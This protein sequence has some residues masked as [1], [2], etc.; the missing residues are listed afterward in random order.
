MQ[1][2]YRQELSSL[3]PKNE[4][5]RFIKHHLINFSKRIIY[6]Y[7]ILD[8][9]IGTLELLGF[10]FSS[11]LLSIV[12]IKVYLDGAVNQAYATPGSANLVSLLA[13]ITVQMLIGFLYFDATQQPLARR[14]SKIHYHIHN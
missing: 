4:I 11:L 12:S 14:R 3:Q 13:I 6:Q 5:A 1:S 2:I 7:F 8:F 9:N 10:T